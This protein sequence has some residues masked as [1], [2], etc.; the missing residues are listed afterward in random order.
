[1]CKYAL[2]RD[3]VLRIDRMA[4]R[5]GSTEGVVRHCL[6]WLES[7]GQIR[8]I[9]WQLGDVVQIARSAGSSPSDEATLIQ[10]QLEELLAEVRA[11]RRYFLRAP[12]GELG[13]PTG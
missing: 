7:R 1:M 11:Y 4:A 2:Q 10:A 9:D 12:V 13:L 3:G 8:M 6:L 5:L